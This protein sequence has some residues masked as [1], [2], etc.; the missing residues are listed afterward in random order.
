[1]QSTP[2]TQ[3]GMHSRIILKLPFCATPSRPP[4]RGGQCVDA[5]SAAAYLASTPGA[6]SIA[7]WRDGD[8]ELR[9]PAPRGAKSWGLL[10]RLCQWQ[11]ALSRSC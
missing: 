2:H 1:M 9:P 10:C 4:R 7:Q 3:F 8:S 11:R 5:A 6:A